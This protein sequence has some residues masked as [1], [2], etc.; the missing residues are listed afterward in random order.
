VIKAF[1]KVNAPASRLEAMDK[2]LA[3]L[4]RA[5]SAGVPGVVR[6]LGCVEDLVTKNLVLEAV[7]GA[8]ARGWVLMW[9]GTV[10]GSS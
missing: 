9:G 5:A 7:P 8:C 10:W 6:L 4:Q 1:G 3:I 2:E